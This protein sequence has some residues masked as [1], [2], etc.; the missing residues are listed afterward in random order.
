MS[1]FSKK[2]T[3]GHCSVV[4]ED[5]QPSQ[6]P[7]FG[8]ALNTFITS[9]YSMTKTETLQDYYNNC[10]TALEPIL[11]TC[12]QHSKGCECDQ[13]S[14]GQYEHLLAQHEMEVASHENQA[15]RILAARKTRAKILEKEQVDLEKKIHECEEAIKPLQGLR[16]QFQLCVGSHHISLGLII[17]LISLVVDSCVNYS[18]LQT[19]LL[20]NAFLLFITVVCMSIMSDVTMMV[21]GAFISHKEENFTSKPLYYIICGGL[22]S[23]FLLSVIVSIMIR[24]GSMDVTYGTIN[25]A[26]EFVGKDSYSLA[27]Y[28]VTLITG[29]ITTATGMLSFAFS[30]DK[31]AHLV[32]IRSKLE[33]E[34]G[35]YK[36]RYSLNF[37]ELSDLETAV[38]PRVLDTANRKAAE[39]NIEALRVNLKLHSRKLLTLQQKDPTFTEEMAVSGAE[40]ISSAHGS[41]ATVVPVS[42]TKV[43]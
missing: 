1:I 43:S 6:L 8:Q 11:A 4:T 35:Y 2:S 32:D 20:S 15:E 29:F 28:A 21:L 27:E 37:A 39:R 34:L 33:E 13:Y 25:A 9:S 38:D 24:F 5:Y 41:V 3:H 42:L 30:L 10:T 31:N 36:K 26:G 18:F 19:V 17:T 12:D 22:L 23:M 7:Y 40:L 16:A 14:D